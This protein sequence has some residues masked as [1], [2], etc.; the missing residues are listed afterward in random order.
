MNRRSLFY[1][2]SIGSTS[3]ALYACQ[4]KLYPTAS[5]HHM[6]KMDS[7]T[8]MDRTIIQIYAPYKKTLDEEMNRIIGSSQ[9]N[10]TRPREPETLAGNF[11]AD[12]L[13]SLGKEIDKKVDIAIATKDGMRTEI[14]KGPITVGNI[15]EFMPFDNYLTLLKIS[16]KD[17]NRLIKFVIETK[18]QP[19]AGLKI[20]VERANSYKATVNGNEIRDDK[21]YHVAT[22][23]YLA[24]GGDNIYGLENP[25]ERFD[26]ATKIREGLLQYIAQ[27]TQQGEK[28]NAEREGRVIFYE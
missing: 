23:D 4:P 9:K 25:I 13:L 14:R 27:L 24:N 20:E 17:L 21:I 7:S 10:L 1:F 16:G 2:L 5:T 26:S 12:A 11:F 18:G 22:Y 3:I 6:Y 19:V 15:Y 8:A 28:V